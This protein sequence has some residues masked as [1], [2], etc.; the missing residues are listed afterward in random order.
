MIIFE[1]IKKAFFNPRLLLV[2]ICQYWPFRY[3]SDKNYLKLFYHAH[4]GKK[5]NL[6]SPV[7]FNEKL[8][9][10][11]LYDR[12]KEYGIMSDKYLVREYIKKAIGEEYLIPLFGVWDDANKIDFDKLPEQFVLKCNHDSGSVF[13]CT[14]KKNFN[15]EK[16]VKK[17]NKALKRQYFWTS[18][19]WNYKIIEPKVI[20]EKYMID[21]SGEDLKDYKFYCFNGLPKFIAVHSG[22][23]TNHIRNFYTLDWE[24]IP[25]Q[26]GCP[27]NPLADIERPAQLEKMIE[28]AKKLSENLYHVRVDFYISNNQVY[29]G[30]LTFHS[31]GGAAKYEPFSYDELWGSYMKL[32]ISNTK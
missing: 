12:K 21:N 5:L 18:R 8:Q 6:E 4:L 20:A 25:V 7:T 29:F 1:K 30:E 14:D 19:E 26:G 3:I 31:A 32:P 23:F 13:I 16:V 22:R 27:N 28:L 17:L 15:K 11:K 2:H 9:W 24:F 10:L